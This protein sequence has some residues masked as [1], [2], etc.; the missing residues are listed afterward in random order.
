MF[1]KTFVTPGL[2][3]HSYLLGD[4]K[5]RLGVV[6]DPTCQIEGYLSAAK[7]EQITIT[8]IVETHVHADFVSGA[9]ALKAALQGKPIIHCSG[10]GGEEWIPTY[11]DH[12][13]RDRDEVLVGS[14]RLEALHTP[15]HTPEHIIWVVYD[16][17]RSLT[18][19]EIAFT[20][21]LLFVGGVGRPDLMGEKLEESLVKQLYHSLF[22]VL[23]SLPDYIE[24]FP[25]HGAGSLCGKS[26]QMRDSSTLGY[27]RR[28]NPWLIP[29]DFNKWKSNLMSDLPIP[30]SYFKRMKQVNVSGIKGCTFGPIHWLSQ[31]EFLKLEPTAA[32]VDVRGVDDFAV[33][34]LKNAIHLPLGG[35]FSSWAGVV[36]S[37]KQDVILVV[38]GAEDAL[39]AIR[40]LR[41]VGLDRVIGVVNVSSDWI[42]LEKEQLCEPL[43][44]I[45]PDQLLGNRERFLVLDVR[46]PTEW[47]SGHLEGAC[48]IELN[49]VSKAI[50]ELPREKQIAV[51][52][53]SG[54]RASVVSSVL[55]RN[56]F[57]HVVNVKGVIVYSG[58]SSK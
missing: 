1:L 20:G 4:E 30:P 29:Q 57:K 23:Q 47:N 13:V 27:E 19:P 6:V 36:L 26:I 52:C 34:H 3:I 24:I 17:E 37:D 21:D 8:D 33:S 46:T 40:A 44:W 49:D 35:A 32:V 5:T 38:K 16:G 43:P 56:G 2:A 14:L 55:V 7:K 15:G 50:V 12:I 28:C 10:M 39:E 11:A 41:L 45:T 42:S 53:R 31:E 51:V 9:T 54:T 25:T 48:H 58:A 22:A 18:I